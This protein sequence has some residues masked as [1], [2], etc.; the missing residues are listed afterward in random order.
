MLIG[1]QEIAAMIPHGE[2]MCLLD[3]VTQWDAGRI[4]CRTNTHLD[5]NNPLLD[6]TGLP[7]LSALEYCAQAAAVH[8]ELLARSQGSNAPPG[9]LA[10]VRDAT[11]LAPRLDTCEGALE[12]EA[13]VVRIGGGGYVYDVSLSGGEAIIASARIIIIAVA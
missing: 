8:G 7:A 6:A 13:R 10:S 3:E 5:P 12:I 1:R 2:G 11:F 4:V 9:W